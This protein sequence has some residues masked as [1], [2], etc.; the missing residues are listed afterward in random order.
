MVQ[1]RIANQI[2]NFHCWEFRDMMKP[3]SI[4]KHKTWSWSR[5]WSVVW[6]LFVKEERKRP[7]TIAL[8]C[9]ARVSV[10]QS[11]PAHSTRCPRLLLL[12]GRHSRRS[13]LESE[14]ASASSSFS[15][16]RRVRGYHVR[17][18]TMSLIL[19]TLNSN[20]TSCSTLKPFCRVVVFFNMTLMHR[21]HYFDSACSHQMSN[22]TIPICYRE[23]L[24]VEEQIDDKNGELLRRSSWGL[25]LTLWW[26]WRPETAMTLVDG[27]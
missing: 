16:I 1:S 10:R 8:L 2:T 3:S 27:K 4:L 19:Q 18:N 14:Q 22:P 21:S 24:Y 12:V 13:H 23:S 17:P 7:R 20:S 9:Q 6:W 11:W 5:G 25:H 15:L 26:L